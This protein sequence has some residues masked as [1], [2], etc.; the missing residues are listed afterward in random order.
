VGFSIKILPE[1][2]FCTVTLQRTDVEGWIM[3]KYEH[4]EVITTLG[5]NRFRWKN[6]SHVGQERAK[7]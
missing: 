7:W 3:V 5:R 2:K 6:T 1:S 4:L